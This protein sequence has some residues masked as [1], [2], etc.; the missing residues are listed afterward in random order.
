MN[1]EPQPK[2][3]PDL[4]N[5]VLAEDF[6][7]AYVGIVKGSKNHI[8]QEG[9]DGYFRS[10]TSSLVL[11]REQLDNDRINNYVKRIL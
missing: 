11:T 5:T 9:I 7:S 6:P 8:F 3:T 1:T 2:T 4:T 10:M